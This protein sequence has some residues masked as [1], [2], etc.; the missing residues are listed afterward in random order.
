MPLAHD[1][2]REMSPGVEKVAAKKKGGEKEGRRERQLRGSQGGGKV[3]G[4]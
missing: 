1:D 3:L 2:K 4:G